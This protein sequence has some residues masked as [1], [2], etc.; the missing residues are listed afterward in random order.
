MPLSVPP[1]DALL[2]TP[3]NPVAAATVRAAV[4]ATPALA[5]NVA[6]AAASDGAIP[7]ISFGLNAITEWLKNQCWFPEQHLTVPVLAVLSFG[8]SIAVWHFI[9][10]DTFHALINGFGILGQAHI[11][12]TSARAADVPIFS[13]TKSE[14]RW[15]GGGP[16][17]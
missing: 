16:G 14:N 6:T 2:L 4:G 17:A 13:P 8:T 5:T 1:I 11:N 9:Q 15:S 7:I 10:H 12:Y 3:V